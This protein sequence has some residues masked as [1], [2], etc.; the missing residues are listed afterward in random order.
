[1][2]HE[3]SVQVTRR[4]RR[5]PDSTAVFLL[6]LA[7]VPGAPA[8]VANEADQALAQFDSSVRPVLTTH[9]VRCHG[10]RKAE[11]DLRIDRLNPDILS[12]SDAEIWHDVLNKLNLGEMPPEDE[13]G[14]SER[15]HGRVVNWITGEIERV[16]EH[17]RS[18]GGRVVMRRLTRYEYSNTM[19]DMFDV[20]LDFG[21]DLPPDPP[22]T[23]HFVNLGAAQRTSSLQVEQYLQVARQALD[24]V[25]VSGP[26]PKVVL[27]QAKL[28]KVEV[29]E[30]GSSYVFKSLEY[31][32]EG[33]FIVKV[34]ASGIIPE[35]SG[36][37]RLQVS[38]GF[39][40]GAKIEPAKVVGD[41][42]DLRSEETQSFEFRGRIEDFPLPNSGKFP[43]VL[44]KVWN[45]HDDGKSSSGKGKQKGKKKKETDL[46]PASNRPSIVVESVSFEG[47]VFD[48]WPP[49]YHRQILLQRKDKEDESVYVRRVLT[50]FMER[51]FRQPPSSAQVDTLMAFFGTIRNDAG[52]LDAAIKETLAMVL[53]APD[54]LYLVE[55]NDEDGKR[56]LD[57]YELA[58]RMSYFLWS[59]MPDEPLYALARSGQLSDPDTL[60]RQVNRMLADPRAWAFVENFTSQWLNLD[61]LHRVAI[62]PEF[63]PDFDESLKQDMKQESL[64]FVAEILRNDLS[65]LNLID[66]DFTMLNQRLAKYYGIDGPR[67]GDFERVALRP[68]HRRGGLLTHSSIM[69]LNSNGGDS[70]PIKRGV[71]LLSRLLDD[72]PPPPPPDVPELDPEEPDLAGLSFKRQLEIHRKKAACNSC[73]RGIDPWGIPFE[74]FDAVGIWRDKMQISN[75]KSKAVS[76]DATATLPKEESVTGVSGLKAYLLKYEK[77]RVSRTIVT[78]ILAYGLG[79][80]VELGDRDTVARLHDEFSVNEFRLRPLIQSIVKSEAFQT[81]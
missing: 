11:A 33:E 9:C 54:F 65:A 13:P 69:L 18:T 62:N 58:S 32:R 31:P 23:K 70:H 41:A 72:P 81:K 67:G 36:F 12:G 51:A 49:S 21:K 8:V 78:K 15:D 19:R 38:V 7:T 1:M 71:W 25:M 14:L 48:Q 28:K 2:Q 40:S 5:F 44:V 64:H 35:G 46:K 79:R 16:V 4:S 39:K 63:F 77:E 17:Q 76:V 53:I 50:R 24:R 42:V 27:T 74:E 61:G 80:S 6:I 3:K 55:P 75:R 45:A 56:R 60:E 22:A 37:P 59:T 57:D 29:V 34:R 66:S 26:E 43:G 73:H 30:P 10:P 52:S 20:D 47:P 68:E